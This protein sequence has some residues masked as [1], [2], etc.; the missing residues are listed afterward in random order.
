MGMKQKIYKEK[1][2]FHQLLFFDFRF[3]VIDG[4]LVLGLTMS[5]ATA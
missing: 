4:E 2:R 1:S 5:G 3:V